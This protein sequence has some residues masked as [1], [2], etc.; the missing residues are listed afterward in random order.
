METVQV[1]LSKDQLKAIDRQ[2][3]AGKYQSRSEAIR[4]YIRK[5]EFFETL[6]QFRALVT[7][8]GLKGEEFWK[9][10]EA[11]RKAL[12]REIFKPR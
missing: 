2:V 1:R 9:D 11:L 12:Y 4:D 6:V 8:A 5:A 7:Q 3:K 10:P